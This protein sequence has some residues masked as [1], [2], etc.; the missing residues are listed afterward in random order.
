MLGGK[1]VPPYIL[2]KSGNQSFPDLARIL[3]EPSQ[4][5]KCMARR[6][7]WPQQQ[8]SGAAAAA[9]AAAVAMAEAAMGIPGRGGCPTSVSSSQQRLGPVHGGGP[10]SVSSPQQGLSAERWGG[11]TSVSSALQGLLNRASGGRTSASPPH[12][13]HVICNISNKTE[14]HPTRRFIILKGVVGRPPR[15]AALVAHTLHF[16]ILVRRL[17]QVGVR[18]CT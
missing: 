5:G 2:A 15:P 3:H 12:H 13:L 18:S 10:P 14:V 9:A 16:R 8:P 6:Q 4:R 7:R 1:H 17:C 11:P